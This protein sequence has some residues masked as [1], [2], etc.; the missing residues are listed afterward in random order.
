MILAIRT[1]NPE[2]KL[3]LLSPQGEEIESDIW[4]AGRDLS[5]Q[6]NQHIDQLIKSQD[7]KLADI[8][9]VIVFAGPGSFTGLRIG[10]SVANA[11]AYSLN[12]PIASGSGDGWIKQASAKLK[13]AKVGEYV[14]P[15]YGG[16]ANITQPRK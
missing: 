14:M 10:I 9:G 7:L 1:D 2:A 11:I 3:Y 4:L 15:E 13:Q 16:E 12:I 6:L 8:T 5:M